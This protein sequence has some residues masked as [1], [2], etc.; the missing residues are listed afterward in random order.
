M[1]ANSEP[2]SNYG[3]LADTAIVHPR[4]LAWFANWKDSAGASLV[5][6]DWPF[7]VV[8][9]NAITTTGDAGTNEDEILLLPPSELP[10]CT[11]AANVS[12]SADVLGGTLEVR[13]VARQ[14]AAAPFERQPE[15]V[16]LIS[17]TGLATP[18]F[19]YR[20]GRRQDARRDRARMLAHDL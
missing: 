16:T 10:V 20:D 3:R 1:A 9:S 6:P 8:A 19:S 13:V 12:V 18:S 4:R 17:G 11:S 15:A 5:K 14:Y 7:K 2:A